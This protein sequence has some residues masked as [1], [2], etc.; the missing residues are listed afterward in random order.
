MGKLF[1]CATSLKVKALQ[2][3]MQTKLLILKLRT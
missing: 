2:S 3:L 1:L